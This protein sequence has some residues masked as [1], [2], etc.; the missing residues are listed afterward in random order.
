MGG[1]HWS[2]ATNAAVTGA[3]IASGT[4]FGYDSHAH[5]VGVYEQHVDLDPKRPNKAGQN[6]REAMDNPDHPT[7][8]PIVVGFDSTG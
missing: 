8:L 3:R 4:T 7:S 5:R 1:G 6:V 2:R